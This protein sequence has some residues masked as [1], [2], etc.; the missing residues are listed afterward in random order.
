MTK[1]DKSLWRHG[2]IAVSTFEFRS[3]GGLFGAWSWPLCC[4]LRQDTFLNIVFLHPGGINGTGNKMLREPC[5][6]LAFHPGGGGGSSN[7]PSHFIQGI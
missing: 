6:E 3:E 4:F 2:S 7:T 5:D 1:Y